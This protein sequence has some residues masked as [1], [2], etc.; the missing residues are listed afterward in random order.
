[1][2]WLLDTNAIIR[3]L[4]GRSESLRQRVLSIDP[5]DLVTC[6]VVKAELRFGAARSRDPAVTRLQQDTLLSQMVSLPFEDA[7]ADIYGDIRAQLQ[8]AG[9]PIGPTDYLIASIA[10]AHDLVLV[11][12]NTAEFAR[13]PGLKIEDWESP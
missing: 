2:T 5:Q 4:N 10:L 11:T 6:S 13:V 3:L 7:A 8:A 9:T 12:H 1:M